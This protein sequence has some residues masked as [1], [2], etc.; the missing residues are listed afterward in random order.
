MKKFEILEHKADLKIRVFGKDKK[1]LFENAMIGMFE[2]A[3]YEPA[4]A[5]ATAGKEIKKEIKVSSLDLPSLLV[6]FLSEVLY[7]S[8]I[9]H[10]IYHQIQFRKL[11]N[12]NIE[13]NLFGEKLKTIGVIIK[14]VTYYSLDIHQKK[15]KTW[16]TTVLFDI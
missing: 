8:E 3:K 4:F 9:N 13:G 5:E 16:E 15:D 2:S 14:G 11:T 12:K 6:D 7:L 1:E 10:E